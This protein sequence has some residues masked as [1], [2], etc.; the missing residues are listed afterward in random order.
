MDY[1]LVFIE[2]ITPLLIAL[3]VLWVDRKLRYVDEFDSIID[4]LICELCE[5]L[6]MVRTITSGID[7]RLSLMK[8]GGW[9]RASDPLLSNIAFN[10]TVASEVFFSYMRKNNNSFVRKLMEYYSVRML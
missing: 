7:G 5:N 6:A 4:N 2:V 10:R 3:I 8:K 1:T 9:S